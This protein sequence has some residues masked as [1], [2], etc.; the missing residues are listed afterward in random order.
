M[1]DNS[2]QRKNGIILSYITIIVNTLVQLVYTP[3][4]IRTLGQSEYGLFSLVSS[5]IGYLSILDLGFGNAIV[6]YTSKFIAQSKT[7][8]EKKLHG[9]FSLIYKIMSLI[10]IILGIVLYFNVENIFHNSMTSIEIHKAK[11]LMLILTFNLA[12]TFFFTIYSSIISAYEKFTY[13]KLIALLSI[14]LK[15]LFMVPLLM[16]NFKSITMSITITVINIIVLLSNYFYCRKKLKIKIKF[17][18]IDKVLL[19]IVFGYSIWLFLGSIV[20]RVNWSVDQVILGVVSG[21]AAVSVYSVAT[22]FNNLFINLSTAISNVMLQKM[23]KLISHNV[24]NE[25]ITNEFIKIGR[26]Q[27]YI[28]FLITTGFIIFGKNF[29]IL[30][31]GKKYVTSYYVTLCLVI[32]AFFSLIQNSGLSI[33][34]AMN[35]YKF[36]SISSIIMAIFNIVISIFLAKRYGAIGAAIGTTIS[37]IICNTILINIYY[38]KE[39]KI[40]VM[41]FW[42]NITKLAISYLPLIIVIV[43]LKYISK[44][45]IFMEFLIYGCLYTIIYCFISYYVNMNNYEKKIIISF[46]KKIRLL[47]G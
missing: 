8:E 12:M 9:M 16:L 28:M 25:K 5:I 26:L 13:Q 43:I 21:T 34:Q 18:G 40:N 46:F 38:Y 2:V 45:N 3:Y 15:P 42:K 36:K 41:A 39:I 1:N 10:I 17:C 30:W 35:K 22:T 6:V 20:D 23:T 7:N 29:I 33:M 31:A 27:F 19:K 37:L 4:L 47:K 32:P 14:L 24:S 44:L 11:I